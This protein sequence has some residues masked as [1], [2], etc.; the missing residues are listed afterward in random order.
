MG[1]YTDQPATSETLTVI[2]LNQT[3]YV[4]VKNG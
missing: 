2:I 4:G 1:I 3:P